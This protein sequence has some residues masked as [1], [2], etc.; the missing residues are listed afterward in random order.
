VQSQLEASRE[1]LDF[2]EQQLEVERS[3]LEAGRSAER[4]VFDVLSALAQARQ[5]ELDQVLRYREARTRLALV[6]GT[7]LSLNELESYED[8]TFL[9]SASLTE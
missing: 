3:R 1:V 9:L 5:Q 8:G 2:R 7:I 4:E 6:S